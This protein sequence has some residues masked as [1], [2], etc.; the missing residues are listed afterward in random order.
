MSEKHENKWGKFPN[1]WLDGI[2]NL[3]PWQQ[4]I[5]DS[6]NDEGLRHINVVFDKP[7]GTI[8]GLGKTVV[9]NWALFHEIGVNVF[10]YAL[11]NRFLP[12]ARLYIA[13]PPHAIS[14][15]QLTSTCKRLEVLREGRLQR[16]AGVFLNIPPPA[17]WLLTC[18]RPN[19]RSTPSE[20]WKFWTVVDE[21]LVPWTPT[22]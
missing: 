10:H 17:V 8:G 4:T 16:P 9:R 2:D 18:S 5:I 1:D 12:E 22:E 3:R 7:E 21:E 14:Q 15:R 13:D 19:I 11:G 6:A 20:H